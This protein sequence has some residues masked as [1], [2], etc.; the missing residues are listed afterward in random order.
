MPKKRRKNDKND[1][2]PKPGF[3]HVGVAFHQNWRAASRQLVG[4][5]VE[6]TLNNLVLFLKRLECSS[7][8]EPMFGIFVHYTTWPIYDVSMNL[9]CWPP[10]F[11]IFNILPGFLWPPLLSLFKP[12]KSKCNYRMIFGRFRR[13]KNFF[14]CFLLEL[15]WGDI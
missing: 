14:L 8:L 10:S 9:F 4:V 13:V 2:F 11:D 6:L 5:T 7:Q 1:F 3:R 12:V 15:F